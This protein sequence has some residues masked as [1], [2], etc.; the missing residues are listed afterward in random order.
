M[1]IIFTPDNRIFNKKEID[2]TKLVYHSETFDYKEASKREN[3]G[4]QRSKFIVKKDIHIY[5]DTLCWVR[6]FSY[7]YNEPMSKK[8]YGH[9]AFGNYPVVG[10]SWKQATAFCEWRTIILIL[11]LKVKIKLLNLISGYQQKLSGNMQHVAVVHSLL[12]LGA[13]LT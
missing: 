4:V 2:P 13:V 7:A 12:I 11:S 5:P 1:P 6:D 9:P 8:Y 3:A 10:V